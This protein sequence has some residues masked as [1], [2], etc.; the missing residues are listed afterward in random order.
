MPTIACAMGEAVAVSRLG[1]GLSTHEIDGV[2]VH[3]EM[4][5]RGYEL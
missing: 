3:D 1:K 4:L 5:R 2:A